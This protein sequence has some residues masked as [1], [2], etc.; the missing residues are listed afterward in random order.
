MAL[1]DPDLFST[2]SLDGR[3]S[4][5]FTQPGGV[6]AE[7]K[8][9]LV[10]HAAE[11]RHDFFIRAGSMSRIVKAPVLPVDLARKHRTGLIG[12]AADGDDR[13]DFAVQEIVHM[14][15]GVAGNI[16]V[17]FGQRCDGFGMNVSGGVRASAVNFH[18]I[19][20]GCTKDPLGHVAAAGV[21][22]A[23]DEDVWF[24][25]GLVVECLGQAIGF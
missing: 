17:D 21:A 19:A 25:H 12:V 10:S 11:F 20:G 8:L 15:R 13:I 4:G 2:G 22:G 18:E 5:A 9:D 24:F 14:L 16:D 7:N 1:S 3:P 23:E 6:G